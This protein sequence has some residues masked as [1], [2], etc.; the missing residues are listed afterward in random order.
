M[1]G[2]DV[3]VKKVSRETITHQE[4]QLFFYADCKWGERE[5]DYVV[6]MGR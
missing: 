4:I 2:E 3:P 6:I 1:C 5:D